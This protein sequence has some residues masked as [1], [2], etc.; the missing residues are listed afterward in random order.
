MKFADHVKPEQK[1]QLGKI[2]SPKKKK[3]QE[4]KKKREEK[5]DWHDLMGSNNRGLYR[6]KGGA[7]KRK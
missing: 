4:P 6:G 2:Q 7:L 3:Q 5:I 1:K